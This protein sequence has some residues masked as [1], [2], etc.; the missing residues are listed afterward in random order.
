MIGLG[1]LL[2]QPPDQTALVRDPGYL[3]VTVTAVEELLR[4]L[5]IVQPGTPA[6]GHGR[7]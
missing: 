2:L 4:H 1:T 7:H 3:K 5:S 6:H